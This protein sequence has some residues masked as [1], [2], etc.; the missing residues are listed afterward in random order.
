ML[1]L[2]DCR[3]NVTSP[4]CLALT[5]RTPQTIYKLFQEA[6]VFKHVLAKE[7]HRQNIFYSLLMKATCRHSFVTW[8]HTFGQYL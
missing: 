3:C 1:D 8:G 4:Y 2:H 7:L 6:A 5:G